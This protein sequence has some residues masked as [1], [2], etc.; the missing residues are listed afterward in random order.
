MWSCRGLA[1]VWFQ[2]GQHV[3]D[4]DANSALLCRLQIF[5]RSHSIGQ[6]N[7]LVWMINYGVESATAG[8]GNLSAVQHF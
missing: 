6:H 8:R 4:P 7:V 1:W 2:T 3:Q 5:P